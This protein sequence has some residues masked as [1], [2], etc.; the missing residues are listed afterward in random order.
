MSPTVV[1]VLFLMLS[2]VLPI[3]AYSVIT[4]LNQTQ[5][6]AGSRSTVGECRT[7]V[8]DPTGAGRG[9]L[10]R[11]IAGTSFHSSAIRVLL[12]EAMQK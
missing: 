3:E 2:E 9:F 7:D 12:L 6:S 1:S 10:H 5:T 11:H 8:I 4:H